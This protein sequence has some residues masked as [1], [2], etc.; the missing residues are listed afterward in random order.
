LKIDN[1]Q[2]TTEINLSNQAPDIY[3][4]EFYN[5][6]QIVRKKIIKM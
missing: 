5:G 6:K 4:I 3:F 2:K 1:L